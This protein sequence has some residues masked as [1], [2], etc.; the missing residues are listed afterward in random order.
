[1]VV[2]SV[3]PLR[4]RLDALYGKTGGKLPEDPD[5]A[6]EERLAGMSPF[7]KEEYLLALEM[8]KFRDLMLQEDIMKQGLSEDAQMRN[9]DLIRVRQEMRRKDNQLRSMQA[10]LKVLAAEPAEQARYQEVLRYVK[11]TRKRYLNS[12]RAGG[13][14]HLD[15]TTP[16]R[17]GRGI[18]RVDDLETMGA[19]SAEKSNLRDDPEFLQF[20]EQVTERDKKMDQA[21][22]RLIVGTQ[23]LH[24]NAVMISQ[25]LK[26]QEHLLATAEQKVDNTQKKLRGLNKRVKKT[27][28]EVEQDKICI[29]VICCVLLL[30]L[31]GFLLIQFK[32]IKK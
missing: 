23:A 15:E 2:S 12:T 3:K 13:G 26:L 20:F 32:V 5:K 28:N 18:A 19:G 16:E 7:Q 14:D 11:T 24:Q 27:I 22:D 21:L 31:V 29:Y 10:S 17:G 4:R 6:D 8:K 1:M 9:S 30:G 25:E